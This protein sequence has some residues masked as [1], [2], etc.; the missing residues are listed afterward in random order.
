MPSLYLCH[1]VL[2][3]IKSKIL[4]ILK[5]KEITTTCDLQALGIMGGPPWILSI[6]VCL[7]DR[8]DS[9]FSYADMFIP[10]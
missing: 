5:G 4:V 2:V 6:T 3:R 10:S 1:I 8:N 7:L 9:H